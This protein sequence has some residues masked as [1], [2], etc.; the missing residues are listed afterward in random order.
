M[1]RVETKRARGSG[2]QICPPKNLSPSC[3][4]SLRHLGAKTVARP[5]YKPLPS[6]QFRPHPRDV[7]ML[8][9]LGYISG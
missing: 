9:A 1:Y 6:L 3:I 8:C 4:V 5:G 2:M 7:F